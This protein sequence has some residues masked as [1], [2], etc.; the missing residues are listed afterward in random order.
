MA[1]FT[2][3]TSLGNSLVYDDGTSIG[4]GTT[5]PGSSYGK[6]YA[7]YASVNSNVGF[8]AINPSATSAA[9]SV[10]VLGTAVTG[11]AYGVVGYN[12]A[13]ATGS[14]LYNSPSTFWID[15]GNNDLLI[16]SDAAYNFR[17]FTNNSERMRI[18]SGGLVGVGA[19]APASILT[20]KGQTT[21]PFL[22]VQRSSSTTE[23]LK[24][25]SAEASAYTSNR[26]TSSGAWAGVWEASNSNIMLTTNNS[27]GTGGTILLDANYVAVGTTSPVSASPGLDITAD[28]SSQLTGHLMMKRVS[29][30]DRMRLTLGMHT[31]NYGFIQAYE[32]SIGG[33]VLALQPNS[34][35]VG[36]GNTSPGA[37]LQIDTTVATTKGLI[38]KG[39]TS[40]SANL[41]EWQNSAGT[42]LSAVNSAGDFTNSSGYN[43][44]EKFGSGATVLG[45]AAT[46]IGNGASANFRSTAVGTSANASTV[47]LAVAVG[48]GS[49]VT[50]SAAVAIGRVSSASGVGSLAIGFISSA[51]ATASIAIGYGVTSNGGIAVGYNFTGSGLGYTSFN[52]STDG[53]ASTGAIDVYA[54]DGVN[55]NINISRQHS[56]LGTWA[57][58]TYAS[59]KG[60]VQLRVNDASTD[61]E[62]I[63]YE[64]DGTYALTSIGGAA[65]IA[66]TTL[67]VQTAAAANKGLVVKGFTSQSGNLQEWQNSAGTALAY[68]DASGNFYAVSKSFLIDHPTPEKKAQGK[69]LRYASLEG[70]ENG[71]YFRGRLE[72]ENVILLPDYWLDLVDPES[73]TVNLTPRKQPQPN[74]FVVDA[75]AEKVVIGSDREICC[76]FIVY[77]T[78]KDIAK[79]EVEPDGN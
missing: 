5:T 8:W 41:T 25:I 58:A 60:R 2:G 65:V 68:M 20:I 51:T 74:L 26:G 27:G 55:A 10:L 50:G 52:A 64:S 16:G 35:T 44:A 42:V 32:N 11:G 47:D 17:V 48:S 31:G 43:A 63:R 45:N 23:Q 18:T 49:S 67:A 70:P 6:G 59:R 54:G 77:G 3:T 7:V 14:T 79:L 4:I 75:D 33:L 38:V 66:S 13:Y 56:I 57:T 76:D 19:T 24:F 28:A 21:S 72:N 30:N 71:V 15:S 73:I 53:F 34:G 62:A 39:F 22:A 69:K 46:A 29:P 36:I 40:Q 61:R 1:K 12:G 9:N 37:K 78:R